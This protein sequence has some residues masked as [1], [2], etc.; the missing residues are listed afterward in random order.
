MKNEIEIMKQDAIENI[1]RENKYMID[2]VISENGSLELS[3]K[4]SK[5]IEKVIH[6]ESSHI[7]SV[8]LDVVSKNPEKDKSE[9]VKSVL[10]NLSKTSNIRF[11]RKLSKNSIKYLNKKGL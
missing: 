7:L 10:E 2:K 5:K 3:E 6:E 8:S 1:V 11:V 9:L 4:D